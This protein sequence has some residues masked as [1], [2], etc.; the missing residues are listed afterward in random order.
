MTTRSLPHYLPSCMSL[1]GEFRHGLSLARAHHRH[2]LLAPAV[3]WNGQNIRNTGDRV[4]FVDTVVEIGISGGS[5]GIR[6]AV[7]KPEHQGAARQRPEK[8]VR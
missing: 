5:S 8:A 2:G 7:L 4:G 6:Q 1:T 3:F